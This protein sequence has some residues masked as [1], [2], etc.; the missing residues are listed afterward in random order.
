MPADDAPSTPGEVPIRPAATLMP[1]RDG[2]GGLEVCLLRRNGNSTWVAGLALFPGGAVDA[3]DAD[4]TL[5]EHCVLPAD[6]PG[7][8]APWIAALRESYEEIG[9][10]LADDAHG[11][12]AHADPG[13]AE[14]LEAARAAVDAGER[15]LVDLL[16]AEELRL[17]VDLLRFVAHWVTPPRQARRYDTRFYLAP[18][19]PGA[20]A[21]P[22]G[23]EIVSADWIAP[24]AAIARH[25]AGELPM[26]PPTLGALHWLAEHGGVKQAVA[27]ADALGAIPRWAPASERSAAA[28]A[29]ASDGPDSDP[30]PAAP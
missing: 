17:R 26:L 7:G 10:L 9:L 30:A 6:L 8:L 16:A 25:D 13:R 15:S 22:D 1:L 23:V 18:T 24:R 28:Q 2:A 12:P 29:T 5:A 20:P 14:R 19:P 4:P 11:R 3:R 21:R 27:A